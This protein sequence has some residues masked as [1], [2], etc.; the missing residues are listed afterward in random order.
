MY[1]EGWEESF[2]TGGKNILP[3]LIWIVVVHIIQIP[4]EFNGKIWVCSIITAA[5]HYSADGKLKGMAYNLMQDNN[6][7]QRIKKKVY[8][9]AEYSAGKIF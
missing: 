4:E 5:K 1:S 3:A 9:N 6:C 2:L 8:H 7:D